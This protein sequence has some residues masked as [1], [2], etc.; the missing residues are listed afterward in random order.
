MYDVQPAR[1][2]VWHF[3]QEIELSK[4]DSNKNVD[5]DRTISMKPLRHA[6]GLC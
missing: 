4:F 2:F 1:D 5:E 3:R 6:E